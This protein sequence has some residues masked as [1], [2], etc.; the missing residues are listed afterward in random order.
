MYSVPPSL[1]SFGA[2]KYTVY[3][4]QLRSTQIRIEMRAPLRRMNPI[5][6]SFVQ[7]SCPAI[8]DIARCALKF[9]LNQ[10]DGGEHATCTTCYAKAHH[11]STH[12][13]YDH[14]RYSHR[15]VISEHPGSAACEQ[16]I[17][18]K[19]GTKLSRKIMIL[20]FVL[21]RQ[22]TGWQSPLKSL[23]WLTIRSA[24]SSIII[25]LTIRRPLVT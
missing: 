4:R 8:D 16:D 18:E 25:I 10:R 13:T 15:E 6:H 11:Q 2:R 3:P 23:V 9:F 14:H 24:T 1:L 19:R 21:D 7:T 20:A 17:M 22:V 5:C 12:N